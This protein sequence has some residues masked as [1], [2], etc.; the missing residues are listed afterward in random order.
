[1]NFWISS[2]WQK[3]LLKTW[4]LNKSTCLLINGLY[5]TLKWLQFAIYFIKF[6]WVWSEILRI[7]SVKNVGLNTTQWTNYQDF[8]MPKSW[9][10]RRQDFK[11]N[12]SKV[13]CCPFSLWRII[14]S[15]SMFD[16]IQLLN[17]MPKSIT[18]PK[19]L[20]HYVNYLWRHHQMSSEF[21]GNQSI[22]FRNVRTFS[23][24]TQ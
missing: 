23:Y 14:S 10:M 15:C 12:L 16:L 24:W 7:L 8:Y 22:Y 4:Y 21:D 13:I 6:G 1:M 3:I 20:A 18:S 17:L 9:C 5:S 2:V 19:L 11:S